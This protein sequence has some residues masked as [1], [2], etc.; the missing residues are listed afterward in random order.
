[1]KPYNKWPS[2]PSTLQLND[3]YLETTSMKLYVFPNLYE[4]PRKIEL[5]LLQCVP[6][7]TALESQ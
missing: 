5:F 1:M 7:V 3:F 6:K 2:Y 4:L